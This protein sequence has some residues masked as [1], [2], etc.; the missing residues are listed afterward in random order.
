[1]PGSPA[2]SQ[3]AIRTVIRGPEDGRGSSA[4][5]V[6]GTARIL[7]AAGPGDLAAGRL[8]VAGDAHAGDGESLLPGRP[9]PEPAEPA[10]TPC[11]MMKITRT[12]GRWLPGGARATRRF[13]RP[14]I[15]L[16][17]PARRARLH[18]GAT[19]V[20]KV[21]G[22]RDP[23]PRSSAP[24]RGC[25][26][27]LG[28]DAAGRLVRKAGIVAVVLAGG[29]IA[30]R[31]R[32]LIGVTLPRCPPEAEA[33]LD[34]CAAGA[35]RNGQRRNLLSRSHPGSGSAGPAAPQGRRSG[36]GMT[37]DCLRS[38]TPCAVVYCFQRIYAS[39]RPRPTAICSSGDRGGPAAAGR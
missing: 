19:A 32:R 33:G 18:L 10:P 11:C 27:V 3:L 13:R 24:V 6:P 28:Q 15:D 21:T 35:R 25:G 22:W 4:R 34:G 9:R 26:A 38:W 20:A 7:E 16:L 17:R 23:A 12:R 31:R 8:G 14:G 30:A 1:M 2:S 5:R 37:A 29:W 39:G 36:G